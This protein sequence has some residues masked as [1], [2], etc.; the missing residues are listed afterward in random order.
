MVVSTKVQVAG[1]HL[2]EGFG[3]FFFFISGIPF[4]F[5]FVHW[6]DSPETKIHTDLF[7]NT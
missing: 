2:W 3:V 4:L 5:T 1:D 7:N 6:Q